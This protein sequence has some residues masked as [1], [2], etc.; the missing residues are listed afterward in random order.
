MFAVA[1]GGLP[2]GQTPGRHQSMDET[3]LFEPVALE[4]GYAMLRAHKSP[5]KAQIA[6]M[7]AQYPS[8]R[9][10]SCQNSRQGAAKR[11][12]KALGEIPELPE[13]TPVPTGI[14]RL[15]EL[16]EQGWTDIRV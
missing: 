16:Q 5:V 12:E 10:S 13:A 8:V 1:K 6:E 14:G 7:R 4:P 15:V 3:A 9:F 11:E 2:A